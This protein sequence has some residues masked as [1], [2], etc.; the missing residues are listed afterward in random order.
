MKRRLLLFL[1]ILKIAFSQF[2]YF[3]QPKVSL[4]IDGGLSHPEFDT[5][6]YME[7]GTNRSFALDVPFR[8]DN[9]YW[10]IFFR[11]QYQ[12]FPVGGG[13]ADWEESIVSGTTRDWI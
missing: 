5:G 3:F 9:P 1:V 2:D 13:V 6:W 11:V 4:H 12:H 10:H 7:L 8:N